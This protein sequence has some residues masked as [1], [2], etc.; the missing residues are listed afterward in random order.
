MTAVL[1]DLHGM[2]GDD[3]AGGS[4]TVPA[5]PATTHDW[6]ATAVLPETPRPTL[7]ELE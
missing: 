5:Q 3:S 1:T 6:H 7:V 4:G 2:A